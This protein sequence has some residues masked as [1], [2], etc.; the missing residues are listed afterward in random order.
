MVGDEATGKEYG[1]LK[2][3]LARNGMMIPDNGIWIAALARQNDLPLAH[4][5][6]HLQ[7]ITAI[8]TLKW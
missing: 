3:E 7:S 1:K 6:A 2:E 4:R 8:K 5:D